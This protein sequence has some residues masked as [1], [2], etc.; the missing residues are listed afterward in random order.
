MLAARIARQLS[1]HYRMQFVCLDD[2]GTLGEELKREGFQVHVLGRGEGLDLKCARRLANLLQHEQID[3]V[4]AHQYTPFFYALASGLFRRRPCVLFTEHGRWHPDY[5]RRKR[6]VF[7]RLMLRKHDRVVGVGQAVCR[8]LVDNEGIPARRVELVYNGVDLARFASGTSDRSQREQVRA[9][10][11]CGADDLVI[12]Q[13]ARLDHLK[14]HATAIRTVERISKVRPEVRLV[15]VGEGPEQ[16]KIEA[17]IHSRRLE[18][19][20]RLLGLR[21]DVARLL[22]AA[23]MFLLT[24]ISEGI[25]LTLIEAM[26]ARLPIVATS[27]GGVPEVIEHGVTGMLA[28]AGDDERLAAAAVELLDDAQ[29]RGEIIE[30]A[31]ERAGRLFSEQ[32]M[33]AAYDQMYRQMLHA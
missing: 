16:A 31:S 21:T 28:P 18:P 25:P 29:R 17:E 22:P 7:N 3:L 4:H 5:P 12:M 13:V 26:A 2:L 24:S 10:I 33:N 1:E 19:F 27:V 11:G 15:L 14:D 23:D 30:R 8:A 6:I 20:V 9:E 32:A